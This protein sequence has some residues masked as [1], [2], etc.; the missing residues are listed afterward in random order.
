[1]RRTHAT[2]AIAGGTLGAL[3]LL[4]TVMAAVPVDLSNTTPRQIRVEIDR[5][6][7]DFAA[8]GGAYTL[9][10]RAA[11][12]ADADVAT[13][14]IPGSATEALIDDFFS[15]L[16][17]AVP[18]SFSD[19]VI[20]IDV[21]TGAVLSAGVTG[22][23]DTVIGDVPIEQTASSDTLAG[24]ELVNFMG[25]DF[26]FLC[27]TGATCTLVP[28][29][30]YDP[31]TGR[32]NAVGMI[33][34]SLFD[35]FAPF[36]DLRL[37]EESPLEC[38]T[39]VAAKDYVPGEP[40]EVRLA[41]RSNEAVTRFIEVKVWLVRGDGLK[42]SAVNLGSDGDQPIGAGE[43]AE[44]ID[45]PL[46]VPDGTTPLGDWELGCRLLEPITGEEIVV[47]RDPFQVIAGPR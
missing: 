43:T 32:A 11:F 4:S 9:P 34:T 40:V 7:H 10:I 15:G 31:L 28:G 33:H 18:G 3:A 36:G 17:G 8:L 25:F 46:F 20:T 30:A 22:V 39:A 1:M 29:H 44:F 6:Q 16:V 47:D 23:L 5:E 38:D 14:T 41:F 42:V 45:F 19:Y 37:T 26:P 24:F 35:A 2:P 13:V 21:D 12:T 27:T